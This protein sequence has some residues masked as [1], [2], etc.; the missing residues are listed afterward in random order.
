MPLY[1]YVWVHKKTQ[2]Q[3]FTSQPNLPPIYSTI[4]FLNN[5]NDQVNSSETIPQLDGDALP[6]SS[7]GVES[8]DSFT[9]GIN[10]KTVAKTVIL[11]KD[12][13]TTVITMSGAAM[14]AIYVL[15]ASIWQISMS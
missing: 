9:A 8:S 4:T 15:Q 1:D 3:T 13:K 12:Y 7:A 5:S 2:Y 14:I 10:V 11:K 6:I